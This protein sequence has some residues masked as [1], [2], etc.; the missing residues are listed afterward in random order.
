MLEI[1]EIQDILG[2]FGLTFRSV[3]ELHD[4]SR[5]EGDTRLNYILDDRYVL[6][7]NS[8]GVMWEERLQ[9]ISRLIHRYRSMMKPTMP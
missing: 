7:V 1:F 8:A 2:C 9:E 3:T 4:T 5:G 6:K